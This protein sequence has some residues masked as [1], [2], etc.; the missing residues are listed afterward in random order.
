[1]APT[2]RFHAYLAERP[3]V[4]FR[5]PLALAN[6]EATIEEVNFG[7]AIHVRFEGPAAAFAA[8]PPGTF[9]EASFSRSM[10]ASYRFA[11]AVAGVRGQTLY[12]AWPES[13]EREQSRRH[14]R[15]PI[16]LTMGY[17]MAG[18]QRLGTGLV[19]WRAGMTVDVSGCGLRV[20]TD[21]AIDPGAVLI[22]HL[23]L[24]SRERELHLQ[25]RAKVVRRFRAGD[26]QSYGL[27]FCDL[28]SRD[29][30]SIV[31]SVL[32]MLSHRPR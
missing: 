25:A 18:P 17:A 5:L 32:W 11:A 3:R 10:D 29:E 6:R 13:I 15:L 31:T 28:A 2:E 12:L 23:D 27:E 24:P 21:D 1:M 20:R 30:E 8:I 22:A 4:R 9:V 16:E 26:A 7:R 19:G 14:V